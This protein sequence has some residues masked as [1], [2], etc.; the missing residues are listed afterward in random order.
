MWRW[1]SIR[2][3]CGNFVWFYLCGVKVHVVGFSVCKGYVIFN[4]N[5]I[6]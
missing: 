6:L 3:G 4:S 5:R 2:N 1:F